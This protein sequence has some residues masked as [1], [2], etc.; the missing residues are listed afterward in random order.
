MLFRSQEKALADAQAAANAKPIAEADTGSGDEDTSILINA[1]A[2]D[3]RVGPGALTGA[4]VSSVGAG[5]NGSVAICAQV[6]T[7]T[8]SGTPA[9]DE[10]FNIT[11][12]GKT[13]IYPVA[14]T[15]LSTVTTNLVSTINNHA[16]LKLLVK[17]S[18][19]L[20]GAVKL[21]AVTPGAPLTTSAASS[22]GEIGRAHV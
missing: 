15:D 4:I 19:D 6:D 17:A 8:I 13:L 10:T 1:L 16:D 2:N 20:S 18:S 5:T 7:L 21:T 9:V 22:A 14:S 11:V 12:N 3:H